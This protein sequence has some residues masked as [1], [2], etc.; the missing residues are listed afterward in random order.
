[1]S[2]WKTYRFCNVAF[3]KFFD[4]VSFFYVTVISLILS[5]N[6]SLRKWSTI[7]RG[8][9]GE[10]A[11]ASFYLAIIFF[12]ASGSNGAYLPSQ[13]AFVCPESGVFGHVI[14]LCLYLLKFS[15][16]FL[17]FQVL[18]AVLPQAIMQCFDVE[19][20]TWKPLAA[21]T[22]SIEATNCFSAVSGGNNLYV[23][24]YYNI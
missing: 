6:L 15:F 17:S 12:L 20:K 23:A 14:A 2:T 9:E 8:R 5:H 11:F 18:L 3:K 22:P 4:I 21:T 10:W 13:S 24:G 1:M 19:V 7:G 16:P